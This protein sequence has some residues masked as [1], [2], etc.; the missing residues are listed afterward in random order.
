MQGFYKSRLP[1]R[2]ISVHSLPYSCTGM[3]VS[4]AQSS[5]VV[6]VVTIHWEDF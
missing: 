5:A 6:A 2:G 1:S 3:K 4:G